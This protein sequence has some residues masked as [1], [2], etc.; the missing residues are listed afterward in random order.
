MEE[1]NVQGRYILGIDQGGTKTAATV[2]RGDGFIVGQ[3]VTR[4]AYFPNEGVESA[5]TAMQEA[6]E[7]ALKSAGVGCKDI[8]LTVAGVGGVDWPGDDVLIKDALREKL[9]LGEVF[10][11]NDAVIAFYSGT[12]RSHGAVI[13]AGTGMNGALIDASG[14]QFVYGDYMEE[15][16]QGG[17]ALARRA[18]RKVFDAEMGLCPP[19]KLTPL[20]LGQ[21]GVADVDALLKRYMT[22]PDFRKELRFLMPQILMVAQ[23]GDET[24]CALLDDFSGEIVAYI[25][26]GFR[27]MDMKPEEEEIVLA[28]SIFKG[29]DNPLTA[30]VIKGIRER[31]QGAEVVQACYEPVVGACI[32]GLIKLGMEPAEREKSIRDSAAV[33]GLLR[34]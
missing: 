30:R 33:L 17:S 3:A 32:M 14:R 23:R 16:A 4:G 5:V 10:I 25:E 1:K 20:F 2:M 13:C 15:K 27:K 28:G 8:E 9:P 29:A 6:A 19:T 26:A 22:E 11:C 31:L 24:A 21:A 18:L 12:L 7:S 34:S